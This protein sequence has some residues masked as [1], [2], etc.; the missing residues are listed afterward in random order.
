MHRYATQVLK[1]KDDFATNDEIQKLIKTAQ[2]V[3]L[4]LIKTR[5]VELLQGDSLNPAY[6]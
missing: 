5:S 2:V 1:I 6:D 4:A 3:R